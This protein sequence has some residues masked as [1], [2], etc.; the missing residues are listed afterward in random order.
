MFVTSR[1]LHFK[2]EPTYIKVVH[3][4]SKREL[5][6]FSTLEKLVNLD[7]LARTKPD[8]G[9]IRMHFSGHTYMSGHAFVSWC[10]HGRPQPGQQVLHLCGVPNCLNPLHL[11]PGTPSQNRQQQQWHSQGGG[12]HKGRVWQPG[13]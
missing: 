6:T 12:S 13:V 4:P 7:P 1:P 11:A 9:Y 5:I 3:T 8:R 2:K 10:F